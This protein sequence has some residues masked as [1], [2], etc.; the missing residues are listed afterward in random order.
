MARL[1][2]PIK[3][4]ELKNRKG[5]WDYRLVRPAK[6]IIKKGIY[7]SP[8]LAYLPDLDQGERGTCVGH[9]SCYWMSAN[10]YA[11]T[12]L[13]PSPEEMKA[14]KDQI[15]N[16]GSCTMVFDAFWDGILSPQWN[17]QSA[18][19]IGNVT[20]PEGAFSGDMA[21]AAVKIG[22]VPWNQCLTPKFPVCV[23]DS[24]PAGEAALNKMAEGHRLQGFATAVSW[25]TVKEMIAESNGRGVIFATNLYADYGELDEEGC[26]R[27]HPGGEIV[28]SH[29]VWAYGVDWDKDMILIK[30]SWGTTCQ[31]PKIRKDFYDDCV[32][33]AYGCIDTEEV[34]IGK[35]QYTKLLISAKDNKGA[36]VQVTI[37]ID[38]LSPID[39]QVESGIRHT[40]RVTPVFPAQYNEASLYQIVD[41]TM[42]QT[43]LE[44]SFTFTKKTAKG[45]EWVR[46]LFRRLF[47]R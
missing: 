28:G 9:A 15:L 42:E 45:W 4:E 6:A 7:K 11:C 3:P 35:T 26:W 21:K 43:E 31:Y 14:L 1:L 46:D 18:R 17:Y 30:N 29:E 40:V 41:P 37:T 19:K 2:P 36:P 39:Y 44:V 22:G 34:L 47:G 13:R 27:N 24:Y 12:G 10:Y 16:L 25:E 38:G 23:P 33:P 8:L 5:S 32:G 20:Y